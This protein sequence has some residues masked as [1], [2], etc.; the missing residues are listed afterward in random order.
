[1]VV[2]GPTGAAA[3]M[4]HGQVAP[5]KSGVGPAIIDHLNREPVVTVELNTSGRAAGDVPAD[6]ASRLEKM[7]LPAGVHYTLGG[8]AEPEGEVAGQIF[9]ALGL[10]VLLMYVILV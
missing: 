6:I 10:A 9:S 1:M 8:D 5:I 2:I 3:T 4:A 7:R